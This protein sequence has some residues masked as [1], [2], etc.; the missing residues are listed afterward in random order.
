MSLESVVG[1][2]L[3][4]SRVEFGN[5]LLASG[6]K[7]EYKLFDFEPARS[8]IESTLHMTNSPTTRLC[9]PINLSSGCSPFAYD[10]A[11]L[12]GCES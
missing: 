11:F 5:W 10:F 12:K 2:I 4:V 7:L 3:L 6:L 8:S 1:K 9:S